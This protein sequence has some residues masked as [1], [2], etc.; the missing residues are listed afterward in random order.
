VFGWGD[1]VFASQ[2]SG[3]EDS[4]WNQL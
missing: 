1:W 3:W 2:V 4:L